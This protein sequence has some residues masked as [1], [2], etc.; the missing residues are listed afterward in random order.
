VSSV[1]VQV[2]ASAE[3]SQSITVGHQYSHSI[4]SGYYGHLQYGS[5][6]YYV[7]WEYWYDNG[8]C[9]ATFK[10]AGT[11]KVPTD[12]VGWKYWSTKT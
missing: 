6:G 2:S 4:P 1:K 7:H 5:W 3:K 9:T 11:A 10:D 8:N 12:A